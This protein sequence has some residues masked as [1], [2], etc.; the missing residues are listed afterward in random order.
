M[1][2]YPQIAVDARGD[3]VV[4]WGQKTSA[5]FAPKC[6]PVEAATRSAGRRFARSVALHGPGQG[7]TEPALAIDSAGTAT[8]LFREELRGPGYAVESVSHPVHGAWSRAQAISPTGLSSG[9]PRLAVDRRGDLLG[10]WS[11]LVPRAGM[12]AEHDAIEASVRLVREPWQQPSRIS[13][14]SAD[15]LEPELAVTP[16]GDATAVWVNRGN[17][18]ESAPSFIE[19]A[20]YAP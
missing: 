12:T 6:G 4:A 19:T 15:A 5:E 3:A 7:S 16:N 1:Y 10:L 17:A 14:A 8:V 18:V 20:D 11:T 13:A 2:T 9:E